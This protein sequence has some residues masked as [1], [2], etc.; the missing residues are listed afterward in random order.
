MP[1]I[2][3]F[4]EVN[5]TRLYYERVGSGNPVVLIHGFG[6]ESRVWDSQF[7]TFAEQYL[8]IMTKTYTP[9]SN[10]K[11]HYGKSTIKT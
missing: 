4:A 11:L 5:G 6:S 3:A 9:N 1:L 7:N 2:Q 8:V 10:A